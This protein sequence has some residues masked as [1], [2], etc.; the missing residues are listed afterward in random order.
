VKLEFFRKQFGD[1]PLEGALVADVKKML[2]GR[3]QALDA[4]VLIDHQYRGMQIIQNGL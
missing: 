4:E 1:R 2:C 3:V